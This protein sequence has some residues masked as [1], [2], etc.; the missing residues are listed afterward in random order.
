MSSDLL[1]YFE[2]NGYVIIDDLISKDL[3]GR[4]AVSAD[5]VTDLARSGQ[6]V[7]NFF[8]FSFKIESFQDF[9]RVV[10]QM[11]PP[12]KVENLSDIWG[13]QHLMH[14]K[15]GEQVFGNLK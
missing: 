5:K 9:V 11:F 4:L 1:E 3:F 15:L 12:W 8:L 10:G 13:V 6:W 2:K 14:Y 7:I